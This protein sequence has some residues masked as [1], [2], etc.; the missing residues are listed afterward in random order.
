M[1][2]DFSS[3]L[4]S[5]SSDSDVALTLQRSRATKR[6]QN[7]QR[8]L[9]RHADDRHHSDFCPESWT[10]ADLGITTDNQSS[11]SDDDPDTAHHDHDAH[12]HDWPSDLG[13]ESWTHP[14]GHDEPLTHNATQTHPS[15]KPR[16]LHATKIYEFL[17]VSSQL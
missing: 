12:D 11:E 2:N 4:I 1:Y 15:T 13:T 8:D 14:Y 9:R 3:P 7:T 6:L 10:Q 16:V 5:S 17:Q